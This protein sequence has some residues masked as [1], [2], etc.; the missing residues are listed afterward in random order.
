MAYGHIGMAG[1]ERPRRR[2][3]SEL[4]IFGLALVEGR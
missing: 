4:G 1:R 2:Y 3:H